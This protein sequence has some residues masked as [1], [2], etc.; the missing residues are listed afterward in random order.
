M[1]FPLFPS[2]SCPYLG[3]FLSTAFVPD[4]QYLFGRP[5]FHHHIFETNLNQTCTRHQ[6]WPPKA[7]Y[8]VQNTTW[9]LGASATVRLTPFVTG[10][11]AKTEWGNVIRK[12]WLNSRC[13]YYGFPNHPS[14]GLAI[15]V[16]DDSPLSVSINDPELVSWGCLGASGGGEALAQVTHGR[17]GLCFQ[18][19]FDEF[20]YYY[21]R[22]QIPLLSCLDELFCDDKAQV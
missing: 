4:S 14:R 12:F 9:P 1:A 3:R 10:D 19:S 18:A 7:C 20:P 5:I 11:E 16:D 13:S 2:V 17:H 6:P 8:P 21:H 22:C 15:T